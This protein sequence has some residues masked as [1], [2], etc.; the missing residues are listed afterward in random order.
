MSE[1]RRPSLALVTIAAL[2][3]VALTADLWASDL[4]LWLTLDGQS[5][6]L[7]NLTRPVA[8]RP[9]DTASLRALGESRVT[10]LIATP[11]PFGPLQTDVHSPLAPPSKQH[12][13]GTDEVGRDVASRLI[14]GT[15]TSLWVG[16]LA[17]GLASILG[18]LLGSVAGYSGGRTDAA[19][20]RSLEV[21]QTFPTLFLLIAVVAVF[22]HAGLGAVVISFGLT[23]S[24][25][26][27]R[28]CR[29][30]AARVRKLDFVLASQAL[31]SS[32][33]R[34]LRV[35]VL[36][37][38]LG[39]ALV[40]GALGIGSAI[41][42]ESALSFLGL[43]APPPTPSWGELLMQAREHPT[44]WWLSTTPGILI[45]VTVLACNG[46]ADHARS[47]LR[48]DERSKARHPPRAPEI[49]GA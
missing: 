32:G 19:L 13:L 15:R 20:A 48:P 45:W 42:V 44:A 38:A 39:P 7:P 1:A 11:I 41:L 28:L 33:W 36:P 3:F 31:G 30:E 5:Y 46:V 10:Q 14:H 21:L 8:L 25:E 2:G 26:V 49:A 18:L 34:T 24:A 43:G 37:F 17:S 6:L 40:A 35:H 12:V 9:Y 23:R 4:P 27:A 16:L 47:G 29:A 22:P